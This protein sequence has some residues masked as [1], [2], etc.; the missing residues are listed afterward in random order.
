[1]KTYLNFIILYLLVVLVTACGG[2]APTPAAQNADQPEAPITV[3]DLSARAT[4][5]NGAVYM[6]LTNNGQSDDALISAKTDVAKTVE[7]HETTMGEGDMMQMRPV[8][9]IPVPAGQSVTLQ[10]GG[11]HVMLI[12][13]QKQL[14]AG[15]KIS[16]TLTFEKAGSMTVEAEVK[17]GVAMEHTEPSA[18]GGEAKI[19]ISDTAARATTEN[20]AVY[21]TLKNEGAED[22]ALVGAKTDVAKTVELHETKMDEN[23]VMKMSPVPNIPIPAGGSVTLKPGGLHVMLIGMQKEL[24]A[25][26]KI[27]LTLTFEKAGPMTIEAEVKDMEMMGK[28]EHNQSK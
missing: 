13:L 23:D 3:S 25:G 26:D 6:K 1:M 27:S 8:V 22:D 24:A 20:G 7:L 19:T 28:M 15:D 10:K 9:N 17:E 12:G 5:E 2:A 11:L 21:M 4:T 16:L 18:A 14:A